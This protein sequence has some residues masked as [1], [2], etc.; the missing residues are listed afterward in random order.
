[1]G[2]RG[3]SRLRLGWKSL[4]HDGVRRVRRVLQRER[5]RNRLQTKP[6]GRGR[7]QW[8][9]T[10]LYSFARGEDGAFPTGQV[11]FDS[12]NTAYVTGAGGGAYNLGV[13]AKLTPRTASG[14]KRRS[15]LSTTMEASSRGVVSFLIGQAI[16][17]GPR[18]VIPATRCFS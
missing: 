10:M 11:S 6:A 16:C 3:T 7:G 12:E 9:K 18:S 8:T 1:M 4:R 15:T 13:V 2:H 17:T 5:L 14:R